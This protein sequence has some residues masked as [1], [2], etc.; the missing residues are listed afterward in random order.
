M[1]VIEP[2]R[3]AE[4]TQNYQ[5]P[6]LADPRDDGEHVEV[7]HNFLR[8]VLNFPEELQELFL[9]FTGHV[10]DPKKGYWVKDTDTIPMITEQGARDLMTHMKPYFNR[11]NITTYS[12]QS[13]FS[14]SVKMFSNS[15][16]TWL[17]CNYKRCNISLSNADMIYTEMCDLIK[18]I[19]EGN[20]KGKYRE[21]GKGHQVR[22]N[23]DHT[24]RVEEKK[25]WFRR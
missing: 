20:L 11:V 1:E 24:P 3:A 15:L 8:F 23:I 5:M 25:G 10:F 12:D 6:E 17:E 16:Q 21:W 22:E 13:S 7:N 9:S 18:S 19:K 14:L 2:Q 4:L